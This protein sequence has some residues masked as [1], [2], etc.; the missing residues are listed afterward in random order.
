MVA[1][2]SPVAI[3]PPTEP[4]GEL[5]RRALER[6][7]AAEQFAARHPSRAAAIR[8]HGGIPPACDFD[9][10]DPKLVAFIVASKSPLLRELD[11]EQAVGNPNLPLPS[12]E[13][14]GG[15]GAANPSNPNPTTSTAVSQINT[16]RRP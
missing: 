9:P 14:A 3:P 7:D 13:R 1:G 10:P 4:T 12:R 6:M 2:P 11:Q 8:A 15:G 5:P 16:L